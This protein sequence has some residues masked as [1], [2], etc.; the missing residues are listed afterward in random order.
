MIE[1]HCGNLWRK[2]EYCLRMQ[3]ALVAKVFW[4][5]VYR[6]ESPQMSMIFCPLDMARDTPSIPG[7]VK[8]VGI[9]TTR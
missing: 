7:L 1:I 8:I 4:V 5:I 9:S 2:H 3:N 6:F